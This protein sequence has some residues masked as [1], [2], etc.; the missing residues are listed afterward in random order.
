[1]YLA[2]LVNMINDGTIT[3]RI[4]KAIA[5]EMVLLPTKKSNNMSL[6]I[7]L[8]CGDLSPLFLKFDLSNF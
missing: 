8:E 2:K 7:I 6:E 4:A 3:G 5:D 1:M